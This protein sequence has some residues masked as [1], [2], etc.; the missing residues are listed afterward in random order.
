MHSEMFQKR[1]YTWQHLRKHNTVILV[2]K[3]SLQQT[4]KYNLVMDFTDNELEQIW[5]YKICCKDKHNFLF[6]MKELMGWRP[7]L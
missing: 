1:I 3:S 7:S 4:T 5:A 6:L 2:K